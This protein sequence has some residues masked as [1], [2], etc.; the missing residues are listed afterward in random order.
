MKIGKEPPMV[1]TDEK[2]LI[3]SN[4]YKPKFKLVFL[5]ILIIVAMVSIAVYLGYLKF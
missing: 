2:K 5:L 1:P 3:Y 4:R